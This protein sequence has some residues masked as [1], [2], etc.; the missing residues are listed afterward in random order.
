MGACLRQALE[1]TVWGPLKSQGPLGWA[2]SVR[3]CMRQAL[4]PDVCPSQ[5][6]EDLQGHLP[7]PPPC[8]RVVTL[9]RAPGPALAPP[10]SF[11]ASAGSSE[12]SPS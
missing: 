11:C 6:Q 7:A 4:L 1:M 8:G 2:G 10:A 9:C 5:T 12:F 3:D